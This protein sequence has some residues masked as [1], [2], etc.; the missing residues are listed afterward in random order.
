MP[1]RLPSLLLA[2]AGCGPPPA[3]AP[4]DASTG[5]TSAPPLED[6]SATAASTGAD[7]S[8]SGST[9]EPAD[10][11]QWLCP[12]DPAPVP[13]FE[14]GWD[15][16]DGWSDLVP[17]GP[18]VITIGGQGAWMIPLGVRGDGFC[19][20]ADPSDYD[21]VPPL[22]VT[23]EAE[24]L[25]EPI[26]MV[27]DFPVSFEPIDEGGL[28]YT[29]IPMMIADGVD[30]GDLEGRATSIRAQLRPRDLPPL[31]FALDGVLTISE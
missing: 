6:S 14:L 11:A 13:Y 21:H 5:S 18:V 8:T 4:A 2:L 7:G 22:D 12:Q 28:G 30:V 25:A 15:Y 17:D 29:F 9:G 27:R 1:R 26:A 23:I 3:D 10:P 24:G 20:P 31:Q 16:K 19:V